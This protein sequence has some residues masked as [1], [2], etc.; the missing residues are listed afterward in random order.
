MKDN[1]LIVVLRGEKRW[2]GIKD[3]CCDGQPLDEKLCDYKKAGRVI[4]HQNP[5]SVYLTEKNFGKDD[6]EKLIAALNENTNN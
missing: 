3:K 2:F 6:W 4:I 1:K 5:R